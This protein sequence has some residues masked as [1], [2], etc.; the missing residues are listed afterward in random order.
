[1]VKSIIMRIV[2]PISFIVCSVFFGWETVAEASTYTFNGAEYSSTDDAL[3]AQRQYIETT[4]SKLNSVEQSTNASVI[5][6]EPSD[7]MVAE[8]VERN[9]LYLHS[10]NTANF[11][12]RIEN[13]FVVTAVGI[14]ITALINVI[15]KSELF[16]DTITKTLY[17]D[18]Y[19]II[20]EPISEPK[21][22]YKKKL[23]EHAWDGGVVPLNFKADFILVIDT[24][25]SP[26]GLILI[27]RDG[28][29]SRFKLKEYSGDLLKV[30][31]DFIQDLQRAITQSAFKGAEGAKIEL[32]SINSPVGINNLDTIEEKLITI[33]RLLD[34]GLITKDEA[35][36]K[37]RVLLDGL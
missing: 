25:I 10:I 22:A 17:F 21:L 4:I 9:D 8:Y 23:R 29:Q 30:Y 19:K 20:T 37:R 24:E 36:K 28:Q 14:N 27:D 12:E 32:N 5:V 34:A 31:Q 33:K 7:H 16:Q 18:D 15:A 2:I 11:L 35:S 26:L 1:M 13:N 6:F 3:N